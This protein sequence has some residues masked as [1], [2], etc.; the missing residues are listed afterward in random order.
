MDKKQSNNKK[1]I[2]II[3]VVLLFI[4]A[5]IIGLIIFDNKKYE[6]KLLDGGTVLDAIEYNQILSKEYTTK[7]IDENNNT[8]YIPKG[9]KVLNENNATTVDKGIVIE[10][11]K[12]NQFVWVPVGT[13]NLDNNKKVD[14]TLGRYDDFKI[15]E[16]EP[17]LLQ[18]ASV[19]MCDEIIAMDDKSFGCTFFECNSKEY[20]N[21]KAKNLKEFI[22]STLNY[23]GYY[24]GRYECGILGTNKTTTEVYIERNGKH[25][26]KN[27]LNYFYSG[28]ISIGI[29]PNLG[30]WNNISQ[31]DASKVSQR[32][33]N[34]GIKTDLINSYAWDTA[35]IFIE[36][37]GNEINSK[38]YAYYELNVSNNILDVT[39]TYREELN[40]YDIQCNIFDLA[41]NAKEW[42][43]ESSDYFLYDGLPWASKYHCVSRG[44]NVTIAYSP[45]NISSLQILK[46][47]GPAFRKLGMTEDATGFRA[48]LYI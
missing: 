2:I 13:I 44:P 5:V 29:Q 15:S 26:A 28:S 18:E 14:I 3:F 10:D 40:D 7:L 35:M 46:H 42:T 8:I 1:P 31:N 27:E 23:G 16:N 48:I 30:V 9:F 47:E 19:E 39:G 32:I 21:A 20:I 22:S 6:V 43:T 36:K 34:N 33:Y 24:I 11:K 17:F 12:G 38:E 25:I 41:S 4:L 37:C 45:T